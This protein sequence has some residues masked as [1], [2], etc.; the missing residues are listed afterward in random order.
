MGSEHVLGLDII[1]R[2]INKLMRKYR[3]LIIICIVFSLNACSLEELKDTFTHA[4][5]KMNRTSSAVRAQKMI[6]RLESNIVK[7]Q[8]QME[9]G[10]DRSFM[11]SR[12]YLTLGEQH[13]SL[14]DFRK[15]IE[16]LLLAEKYG[17]DSAHMYYLLGATHANL[18]REYEQKND[19]QNAKL[20]YQ[21]AEFY[22]KKAVEVKP[23][24]F[25]SWYGLAILLFYTKSTDASKLEAITILQQLTRQNPRY[26]RGRLA[27]GLFY[28]ETKNFSASLAEYENLLK[29]LSELRSN[30]LIAEYKEKCRENITVV[31][32][33]ISKN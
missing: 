20:L 30:P 2:E 32:R 19:E 13:I 22:Y 26:Y 11:I 16:A 12:T 25:D 8:K 5:Y 23:T 4:A 7:Y 31:M 24:H 3:Q 17:L 21:N 27:L 33:E 1:F 14:G 10:K 6:T 29:D 15:A 18:G 28:F 9:K